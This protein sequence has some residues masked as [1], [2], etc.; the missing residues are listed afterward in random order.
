MTKNKESNLNET[1]SMDD[2]VERVEDTQTVDA[3]SKE[4][5]SDEHPSHAETEQDKHAS[6]DSNKDT[7]HTSEPSSPQTPAE[8]S[9][10]SADEPMA[11]NKD[12]Q[13]DQTE[14]SDDD[15][16]SEL[17]TL[18]A[19]L[20]DYKSR[21]MRLYAE[22][23][24]ARKRMDR[25]KQDFVKYAN[26]EV[27]VGFLSILDNLEL[28]VKAAIDQ[29]EDY[30][31]F[32]KGIEMVMTQVYELLKKHGVE[33]ISTDGQK[34]DPHCHEILMQEQNDEA[35]DGAILEVFQKGYRLHEK[36]IR[37]AKIKINHKSS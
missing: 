31:A 2:D 34:F 12:S 32:R 24:N 9:S 21:Y 13:D 29:H 33:P 14:T 17:E 37:T 35:E 30:A 10:E 18:R 27:L 1:R 25:E 15:A 3:A 7:S 22:F 19:Q 5:Q 8:D 4:P 6:P 11:S 28:S 26:E 16:A 20:D 36:V 23:E